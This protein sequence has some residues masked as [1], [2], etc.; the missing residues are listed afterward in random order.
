M[1]V[2][3]K[4]GTINVVQAAEMR[5]RNV[6]KN[7]LPV[8][9]SFSGGKDSLCLANVTLELI[10][11]GEIDPAQLTVQFI[12]EEAIF[13][14]IE[15]MTKQWRRKFLM[16][17][18]KFTWYCMQYRHFNCFNALENDESFICWDAEKA[19]RWVRQPPPFAIRND[20]QLRERV[21][22]YQQF[23]DKKC[24]MG[25]TMVGVRT[26]ESLQRL[27][28][29]AKVPHQRKGS[30]GRRKIYP[31]YDWKD[32]DVW[33]YLKEHKVDI[34]DIYLYMWQ[35]GA[36]RRQMRV[37]QF[38]SVDTARSLVKM[39][40]YYPHL[41]DSI[42]RREPNAYL[43]ALYWDSEMF[44]RSTRTRRTLEKETEKKDYRAEL[45][46]VF[47]NFDTYFQTKHKRK[48][49]SA[50]RNFYL[51]TAALLNDQ[52]AKSLYESLMAGDPKLRSL[53]A[54]YQNVYSKYVESAK[55][56]LKAR[57]NDG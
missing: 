28:N 19:D 57:P 45:N 3:R 37:S 27:Q 41:L 44:G 35:A 36:T 52:Q 25:M 31:I 4:Q 13:P 12:D 30:L 20:P 1:A 50:Y 23:L 29:I 9:M 2:K 38:F 22:S 18:A 10:Q 21:D 24:A 14:C 8:Y 53:R 16:V 56:E 40:E 15:E 34:P 55:E 46:H 7:G 47:K 5:V 6:F 48:V 11:R 33:L 17:G 32:S 39:N 54:L 49:A 42:I 26:A 51:S 43:A